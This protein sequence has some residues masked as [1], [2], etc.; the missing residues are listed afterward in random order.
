MKPSKTTINK[1]MKFGKT[2]AN[3]LE[4]AKE[5]IINRLLEIESKGNHYTLTKV[6][7]E[8]T[9]TVNVRDLTLATSETLT[10]YISKDCESDLRNLFYDY[11]F[12]SGKIVTK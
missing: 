4:R 7:Q 3:L 12:L 1:L 2:E 11:D 9:R 5:V 8:L 10:R 6:I